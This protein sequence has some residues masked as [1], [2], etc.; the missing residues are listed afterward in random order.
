MDEVLEALKKIEGADYGEQLRDEHKVMIDNTQGV[1]PST[2]KVEDDDGARFLVGSAV[3]KA[4]IL[5][6][7]TVQ[8]YI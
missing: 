2:I 1:P 7:Q 8:M 3:A 4:A 5:Q 6:C